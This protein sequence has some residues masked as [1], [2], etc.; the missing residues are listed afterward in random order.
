MR[1]IAEH[2]ALKSKILKAALIEDF[3]VL[4]K[5]QEDFCVL[6]KDQEDF[7]EVCSYFFL[8]E[9]RIRALVFAQP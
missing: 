4:K 5:D 7:K 2:T 8:A 3:C 9:H 6:K 1:S